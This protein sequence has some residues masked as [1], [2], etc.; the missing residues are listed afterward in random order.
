M[1]LHSCVLL[2]RLI[3]VEEKKIT[4]L[5]RW[6]FTVVSSSIDWPH[7]EPDS[8]LLILESSDLVTQVGILLMIKDQDSNLLL[9]ILLMI[10]DQDSKLLLLILLMIGEQDYNL[11][12]LLGRDDCVPCSG[13]LALRSQGGDG[14]GG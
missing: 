2:N 4:F 1:E 5:C 10:K 9:L 6:N 12:L 8:L 14:Q 13:D 11:L 3:F 7:L